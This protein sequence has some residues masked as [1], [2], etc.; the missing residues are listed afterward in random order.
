M[1]FWFVLV[2]F[3]RE[4]PNHTFQ[5]FKQYRTITDWEGRHSSFH[6]IEG[7]QESGVWDKKHKQMKLWILNDVYW[8]HTSIPGYMLD[9]YF[10][11]EI[12][13]S[14]QRQSTPQLVARETNWLEGSIAIFSG[15]QELF[16]I[17]KTG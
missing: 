1:R 2:H 7:T 5:K 3:M 8:S 10:P 9:L 13:A 17:R 11:T 12:Q 6:F 15:S 14:K 16:C 4:S